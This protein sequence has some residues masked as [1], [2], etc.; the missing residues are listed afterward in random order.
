MVIAVVGIGVVGR[1]LVEH[2]TCLGHNVLQIERDSRLTLPEAVRRADVVFIVT[3]PIGAVGELLKIAASNMRPNT[4]LVHG[5]SV[6]APHG[7]QVDLALM[8]EQWITLAHVHFHFRPEI[9]LRETLRGQHITVKTDVNISGWQAW[10]VEAFEPFQPFI[11]QLS[12][13]QHD[14]TTTVSQLLHMAEAFQVARVWQ[15]TPREELVRGLT[16][17]GPPGRF[18]ARSVLRTASG[19]G[20][21]AEIL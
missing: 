8:T 10:L 16:I 6:E 7:E 2:F 1:S 21:A 4:L 13:N 17:M 14:T 12:D 20:V 18:L 15:N 5:T 3:R 9:P 11:H 19:A